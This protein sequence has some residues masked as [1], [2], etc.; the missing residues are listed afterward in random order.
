MS[1][2]RDMVAT[3]SGDVWSLYRVYIRGDVRLGSFF[4]LFQTATSTTEQAIAT[5]LINFLLLFLLCTELL[6]IGHWR[7]LAQDEKAH[8]ESLLLI[9]ISSRANRTVRKYQGGRS[10]PQRKGL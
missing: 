5:N 1:A 2:L 4:F 10:M 6:A 9:A 7:D 8:A 3:T